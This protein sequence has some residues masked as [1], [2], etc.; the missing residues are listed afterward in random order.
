M[1]SSR[2]AR[3]SDH[4]AVHGH[5]LAG[6]HTEP[7]AGADRVEGHIGLA[8]RLQPACRLRRETHERA[9]GIA[10]PLT[11][12]GFH[13]LP[14]QHEHE[15]HRRRLEVGRR[16]PACGEDRRREGARCDHAGEAEEPGGARAERD[17]GPHV[18]RA[19][20]H[21]SKTPQ[22]EGAC[23]PEHGRRQQALQRDEEPRADPGVEGNAGVAPHLQREH[24]ACERCGEP[25]PPAQVAKLG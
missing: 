11:G 12:S 15:D 10:R 20:A 21:R 16:L 4:D 2:A 1:L 3:P 19:I 13:H 25:E 9:D 23:D 14:N 22:E 18:G 6:P 8:A 7:V 5:A 17:Q 24:G